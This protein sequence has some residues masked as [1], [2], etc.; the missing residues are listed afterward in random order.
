MPQLTARHVQYAKTGKYA[1]GNGLY[2]YVGSTGWRSWV[3]RVQVKGRRREIGL[4]G[5]QTQSF[6]HVS[7][8]GAEVPLEEKAHLTLAEAREI[9]V[10]LRNVAKAGRDP[11][12]ER[13]RARRPELG[14]PPSFRK[15]AKATHEAQS[16]GWS[17]RTAKAF[18]SSLKEHAY[19]KLGG[20]R[21]D[22]IRADDVA[23]ALKLIGISKPSMAKKV[24]PRIPAVLVY[25]PAK[26]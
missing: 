20:M 21:V 26:G 13:R 7:A 22:T 1:D 17:D 15:A 18:L 8:V 12:E 25:S 10:R 11:V 14:L 16:H 5:V 6:N 19:P 24:R 3:L 23:E 4:G 2:L 9:C